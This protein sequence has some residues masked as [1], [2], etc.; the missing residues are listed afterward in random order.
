MYIMCH[1]YLDGNWEESLIP[2]NERTTRGSHQFKLRTPKETKN[3]FKSSFFLRTISVEWNQLPAET[4]TAKSVDS[5]KNSL[6]ILNV[7]AFFLFLFCTIF[8]F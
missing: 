3:I 5:F 2:N 1:G 6:N 4:V 7:F 8:Q